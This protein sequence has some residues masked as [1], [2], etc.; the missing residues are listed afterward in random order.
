MPT[1][2]GKRVS[3]KIPKGTR[4]PKR[5]ASKQKARYKAATK[6]VSRIKKGY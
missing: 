3:A 1:V 5:A 2:R 4:S 6:K